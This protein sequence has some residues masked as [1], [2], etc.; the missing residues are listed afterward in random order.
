MQNRNLNQNHIYGYVYCITNKF[1]PE[2]CKIGFVDTFNKTSHNR[3]KELSQ[4][5]SCP[6]PFE[7][8]FDIRVKNPAK[9]EKRIHKKL[10]KLRVNKNREFFK[11]K[12]KDLIKFFHK[13]KLIYYKKK[14]EDDDDD[15]DDFDENYLTIYNKSKFDKINKFDKTETETESK[16]IFH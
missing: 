15:D 14:E 2:L 6:F 3:A 13:E 11:I 8:I 10:H 1:M 7:V 4:N 12:P 9:Y 5:T 16:S